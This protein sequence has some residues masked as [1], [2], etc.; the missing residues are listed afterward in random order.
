METNETGDVDDLYGDD[1][2]D[3]A[4]GDIDHASICGDTASSDDE[5]LVVSLFYLLRYSATIIG[6]LIN[7]VFPFNLH[8]T[9][10]LGPK[11][12]ARAR[13]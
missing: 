1:I 8:G 10:C 11:R 6:V 7:L 13:S 5:A 4:G 12:T 9:W 3:L 2:S